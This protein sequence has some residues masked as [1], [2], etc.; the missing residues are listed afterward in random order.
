[1]RGMDGGP[2]DA[3]LL[4]RRGT[5]ILMDGQHSHEDDNVDCKSNMSIKRGCYKKGPHQRLFVT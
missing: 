3:N 4:H 1:M 2:G 5:E